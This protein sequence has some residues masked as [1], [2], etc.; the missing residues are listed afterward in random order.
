MIYTWE[1]ICIVSSKASNVVSHN[2]LLQ[3]LQTAGITD[4]AFD[5]LKGYLSDRKQCTRA[6]DIT[7]GLSSVHSGITQGSSLGPLLFI[8]YLNYLMP[9][10]ELGIRG[11]LPTYIYIVFIICVVIHL[12]LYASLKSLLCCNHHHNYHPLYITHRS[13]PDLNSC[14]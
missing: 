7:S 12:N 10:M 4:C 3:K 1:C 13:K 6:Q 2:I 14:Q 9:I 11:S 8:Y 5:G